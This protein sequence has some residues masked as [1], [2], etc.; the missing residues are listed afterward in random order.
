MMKTR[1][2][3]KRA[4]KDRDIAHLGFAASGKQQAWFGQRNAASDEV[5]LRRHTA[6]RTFVLATA[7]ILIRQSAERR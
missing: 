1:W 5:P 6:P 4:G 2:F 3:A 7:P